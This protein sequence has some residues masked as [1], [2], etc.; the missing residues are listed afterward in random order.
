MTRFSRSRAY[1]DRKCAFKK[2][3]VCDALHAAISS[4]VPVTTTSPPRVAALRP[5]IDH[6][7]G[8]LDHVQ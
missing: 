7:V 3:P 8:R 2:R 5:Q 6:V 4:G 1:L